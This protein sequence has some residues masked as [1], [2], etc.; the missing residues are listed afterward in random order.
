VDALFPGFEIICPRFATFTGHH[1]SEVVAD[2]CANGGAVL[3]KMCSNWRDI[4]LTS[5]SVVLSIGG[6][7][8]QRGTGSIVLNSP[9]NVLDWFVNVFSQHGGSIDAGQFVMTGTMTGLH[10]TEPS[11]SAKADFDVLGTVEVVFI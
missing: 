3:G 10:A 4:D 8:R 1:V 11:H 5:Q 7:E 2:F 6:T 9:L